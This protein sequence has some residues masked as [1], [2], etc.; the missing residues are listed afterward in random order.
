MSLPIRS[1]FHEYNY[2][3]PFE[4]CKI[5]RYENN[6]C[7]VCKYKDEVILYADGAHFGFR[8]DD[9]GDA[10]LTMLK[11]V[12]Q[13]MVRAHNSAFDKGVRA[14]KAQIKASLRLQL[15]ITS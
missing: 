11:P 7:I 13:E 2:R 4:A 9:L 5:E 3:I 15:G 1:R 12:F 10:P 6:G 14:G 8:S